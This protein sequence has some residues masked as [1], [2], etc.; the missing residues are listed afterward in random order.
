MTINWVTIKVADFEASKA[1]YRDYLGLK[2]ANEMSA[3][4]MNL[5]FFA[6]DKGFQIELI[7]N[8]AVSPSRVSDCISVG[9]APDDYDALLNK[10]RETGILAAE[11]AILG[12]HLECFFVTDPNGLSVQIIKN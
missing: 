7:Y 10:A 1:F 6:D 4:P 11:P 12:G 8:A 9:V 5:A 3:G 2:P